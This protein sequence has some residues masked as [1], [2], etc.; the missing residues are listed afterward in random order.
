M[1]P[2]YTTSCF[3]P[4]STTITRPANLQTSTMSSGLEALCKSEQQRAEGL[5]LLHYGRSAEGWTEILKDQGSDKTRSAL[6]LVQ[7]QLACTWQTPSS[8]LIRAALALKLWSDLPPRHRSFRASS[9]KRCACGQ[10]RIRRNALLRQII[11]LAEQ[12]RDSISRSKNSGQAILRG[13]T[14]KTLS[15]G[16]R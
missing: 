8:Y 16:T 15:R 1:V 4:S 12:K 13:P 10:R 5:W 11:T 3:R 9:Q 2:V 7:N 6:A 14:P